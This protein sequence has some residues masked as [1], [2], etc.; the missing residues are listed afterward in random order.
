VAAEVSNAAEPVRPRIMPLIRRRVF[1]CVSMPKPR[2]DGAATKPR[3]SEM[4]KSSSHLKSCVRCSTVRR[5]RNEPARKWSCSGDSI[6]SCSEA[7]SAGGIFSFGGTEGT[8]LV[9]VTDPTGRQGLAVESSVVCGVWLGHEVTCRSGA[10]SVFCVF[11]VYCVFL[12][13]MCNDLRLDGTL[14]TCLCAGVARKKA[15]K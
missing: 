6:L 12:G 2:G 13:L 7:F 15:R 9:G 11:M 4:L 8:D 1:R 5:A 3:T 10:F 14:L